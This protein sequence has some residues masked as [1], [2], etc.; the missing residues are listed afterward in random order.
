[1]MQDIHALNAHLMVSIWP[2]MSPGGENWQE[3]LQNGFLLGNHSTYDAFNPEARKLYW[4]QA[5]EGL[6]AHGIDAWWCDCTEPFEADWQGR[7]Q[8]R[9]GGTDADQCRRGQNLLDPV[10]V[11]AYSLLHSQGIYEGQR[12]SG[13]TKR[14]VNLTRSGYLGQQ[15]YATMVWSGDITAKW[16]TLRNQI[17]A[18]PEFLRHRDALLDSGYWRIFCRKTP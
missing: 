7:D 3:M 10:L 9:A 1:M 12:N 11:N 14:V 4:K 17:A 5:Q 13:S 18:R 2:H 8:T 6:F 15:R 16:S